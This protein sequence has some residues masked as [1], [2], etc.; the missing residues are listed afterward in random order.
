[1]LHHQLHGDDIRTSS[2]LVDREG[3]SS[4]FYDA[5]LGAIVDSLKRTIRE[6][7]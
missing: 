6:R 3:E 7:S 2:P 5:G 4:R 1:M